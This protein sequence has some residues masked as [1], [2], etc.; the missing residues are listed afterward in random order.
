MPADLPKG[1]GQLMDRF[2]SPMRP[3][4]KIGRLIVKGNGAFA[5]VCRPGLVVSVA[6]HTEDNDSTYPA[7]VNPDAFE[8]AIEWAKT[9][10]DKAGPVGLFG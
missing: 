1:K 4:V 9:N 2:D 6:I 8:R 7:G 3:E 5:T 10:P